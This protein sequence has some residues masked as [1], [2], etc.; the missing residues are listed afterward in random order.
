M[1]KWIIWCHLNDE[2]DELEKAF[3][4]DCVSIRGTT[5]LDQREDLE[6]SWRE[7]DVPI[8]ISKPSVFGWGMN[9]QHCSHMVFVGVSDSFEEVY[10]AE[11]RI[12]RFGQQSEVHIHYIVSELE[13]AVV[14]NIER[15]QAQ[16][17]QMV[18]GMLAHMRA[19]NTENVRGL[20]RETLDYSPAQAM[21]LP[22]WVRSEVYA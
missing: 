5:P 19:L 13:G 10:Q 14:R 2:Q 3:G 22:E 4:K 16:F 17:E 15:K 18:S 8:L 20:E 7:G 11:R 12:W 9:W 1:D 6:R 21:R